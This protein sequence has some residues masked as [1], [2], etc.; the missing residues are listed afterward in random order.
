MLWKCTYTLSKT[1][2]LVVSGSHYARSRYCCYKI[3][4]DHHRLNTLTSVPP[5]TTLPI[6]LTALVSIASLPIT[7]FDTPGGNCSF[8]SLAFLCF[9]DGTGPP[10]NKVTRHPE[11][12]LANKSLYPLAKAFWKWTS[13]Q[14]LS[15]SWR[16][17]GVLGHGVFG[18][19]SRP[20]RRYGYDMF[21]GCK[22]RERLTLG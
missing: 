19:P 21:A 20:Q 9:L 18:L 16:G 7:A 12:L 14:I 2:I 8:P 10:S 15:S 13:F 17:H 5:P 22:A 3:D 4:H 1:R 6:F 11:V